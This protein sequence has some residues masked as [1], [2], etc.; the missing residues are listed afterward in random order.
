MV[1]V[2]VESPGCTAAEDIGVERRIDETGPQTPTKARPDVPDPA[3]LLPHPAL[4]EGAPDLGARFPR[5]PAEHSLGRYHA[6]LHRG[7]AALDLGHVEESG[8]VADQC[9]TRKIEARDRLKA[10]LVERPRAIGDPSAAFEERA[11]RRMRLEA[12]KFLERVEKR[13]SVI[14]PDYKP[15]RDLPIFEVIEKRAA[16]GS[17]VERPADGMDH[18][19]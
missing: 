12:L 18:Q 6:G 8:G 7:M 4:F 10:A 15:D 17:R 13:V 19:P 9:A 3:Q 14:E 16:I 5:K 11:D 1:G 2:V